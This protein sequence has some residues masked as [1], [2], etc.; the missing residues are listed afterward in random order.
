MAPYISW[1]YVRALPFH[2]H[3]TILDKGS[4]LACVSPPQGTQCQTGVYYARNN[5]SLYL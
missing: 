1:P 4:F 5:T 3:S 2:P